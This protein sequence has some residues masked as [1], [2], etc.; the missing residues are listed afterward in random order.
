MALTEVRWIVFVQ[1]LV[2]SRI[3]AIR[4]APARGSSVVEWVIITA[5]VAGAALG[6]VTL[7]KLLVTVRMSAIQ[8]DWYGDV[9]PAYSLR[10]QVTG[11]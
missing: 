6:L 8:S 9:L 5:V 7:I 2:I 10:A 4:A 3:H 11:M 1:A